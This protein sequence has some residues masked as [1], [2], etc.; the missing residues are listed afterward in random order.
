MR[1]KLLVGGVL[2]S[3]GFAMLAPDADAGWRRRAWRYGGWGYGC[4]A[5]VAY[6][7]AYATGYTTAYWPQTYTTAY[8][9]QTTYY[10]AQ[11][12]CAVPG[13]YQTYGPDGGA[14]T[15][16]SA[17]IYPDQGQGVQPAGGFQAAPPPPREFEDDR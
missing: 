13:G 2:L 3:V 14:G 12:A 9:P 8:M 6:Q 11:T 1:T 5:P 10:G 15:Y 4:C 17:G 7:G 16:G